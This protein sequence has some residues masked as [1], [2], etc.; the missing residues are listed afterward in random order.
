MADAK[1]PVRP[2]PPGSHDRRALLQAYQDV[3]R[4]EEEKRSSR[5]HPVKEAKPSRAPFWLG[6]STIIAVLAALLMLQPAW[7]FSRAPEEGPELRQ[8][9]LRVRMYVEIDRIEH[10]RSAN[11]RYPATLAE[12]GADS[13]GLAYN[14]GL[15]GF[16][17]SGVNHGVTLTYTSSQPSKEFLG[18]SYQLLAQRRRR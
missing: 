1:P 6:M 16:S 15:D 12:A 11:G 9:S 4:N 3:I 2:P 13:T 10:F 5:A 7:L 18:D 17:L 8:A 14:A